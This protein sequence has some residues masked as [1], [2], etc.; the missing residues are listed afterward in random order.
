M[1]WL[2]RAWSEVDPVTKFV[3]L[4]APLEI[5]LAGYSGE[6]AARDETTIRAILALLRRHGGGEEESLVNTF[7]RLA[8]RPRASLSSRFH[9]M[10]HE[11][12]FEECQRDVAAFDHFNDLRNALLHRG[13]FVVSLQARIGEEEVLEMETLVERYVGWA[14][15]RVQESRLGSVYASRWPRPSARALSS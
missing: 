12:N 15:F 1:A 10:A 14:L 11:A 8:E 6:P 7:N 3:A 5:V 4:F 2:L 13:E 9:D